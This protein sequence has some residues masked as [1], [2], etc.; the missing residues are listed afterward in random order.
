MQGLRQGKI[1]HGIGAIIPGSGYPNEL[2]RGQS[3]TF[4]FI[5]H[6]SLALNGHWGTKDYRESGSS[7]RSDQKPD[8]A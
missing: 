2:Q 8:G 5:C 1:I 4:A 3:D 7:Y 6:W